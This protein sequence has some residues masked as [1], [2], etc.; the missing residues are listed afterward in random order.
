M[1][2]ALAK[3]R[4]VTRRLNIVVESLS[5]KFIGSFP[6]HIEDIVELIDRSKG[7]ISVLADCVDYGSL[8]NYQLHETLVSS[9]CHAAQNGRDVTYVILD[10]AQEMSRANKYRDA[11]QRRNDPEFPYYVWQFVERIR[12]NTQFLDYLMKQKSLEDLTRE[13]EVVTQLALADGGPAARTD[14]GPRDGAM[15]HLKML[16]DAFQ[17]Y[18]YHRME[19]AKVV[20]LPYFSGKSH[21]AELTGTLHEAP[22]QELFFWIVGKQGVFVAPN[23]GEDALSFHSSDASLLGTLKAMF[24]RRCAFIREH[25]RRRRGRRTKR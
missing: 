9:I 4:G 23:Y 11:E 22:S 12:N 20:L 25:P 19:D 7:P 6:G 15:A 2:V 17:D 24:D 14:W 8:R 18:Q 21:D 1:K 10:V 3:L 5:T 13:F 16:Q